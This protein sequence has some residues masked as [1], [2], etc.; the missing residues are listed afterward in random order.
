MPGRKGRPHAGKA[1]YPP[2]ESAQDKIGDD[3]CRGL[4][5][6][7][8]KSRLHPLP[9]YANPQE[10][11]HSNGGDVG[12][13]RGEGTAVGGLQRYHRLDPPPRA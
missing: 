1:K 12:G 11:A 9:R 6:E 4:C 8:L 10:G 3:D 7:V 2:K 5:V 13:L